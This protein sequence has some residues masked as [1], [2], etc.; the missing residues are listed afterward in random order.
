M[1]F[2][3]F[4]VC[5]FAVYGLVTLVISLG[6][7]RFWWDKRINLQYPQS[8]QKKQNP[9]KQQNPHDRYIPH[10]RMVLLVKDMEDHLEYILRNALKSDFVRIFIP[11]GGITVIDTG[12]TDKTP[13][14]VKQM[15]KG[16]ERI[17]AV[18][19]QDRESI[20]NDS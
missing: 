10:I 2:L 3:R 9:Q 7:G 17:E 1:D 19:F 11:D 15:A 5:L 8:P 12:S 20:F 4:I 16:T 6:E 18:E 13:L 14:L